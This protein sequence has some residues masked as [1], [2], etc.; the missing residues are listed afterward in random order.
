MKLRPMKAFQSAPI[1]RKWFFYS[2][3][4]IGEVKISSYKEK[5]YGNILIELLSIHI[6]RLQINH[7]GILNIT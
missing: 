2:W 4:R 7:S 5:S 6:D 1:D 3:G